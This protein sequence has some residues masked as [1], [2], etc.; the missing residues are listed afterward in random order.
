MAGV[1]GAVLLTAQ[2]NLFWGQMQAAAEERK[3]GKK[4]GARNNN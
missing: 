3:E 4:E 1:C 2:R